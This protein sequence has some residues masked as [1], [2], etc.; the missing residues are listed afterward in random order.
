MEIKKCKKCG[1]PQC[2]PTR[3]YREGVGELCHECEQP[4]DRSHLFGWYAIAILLGV[5]IGSCATAGILV[6]LG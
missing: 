3:V 2:P 1:Y 5:V 4:L 6:Y